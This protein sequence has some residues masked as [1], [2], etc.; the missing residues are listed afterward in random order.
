[1]VTYGATPVQHNV[2]C[3]KPETLR[4]QDGKELSLDR[5]FFEQLNL[6]RYK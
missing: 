2:S 4:L 1:M 6:G 5:P 3:A